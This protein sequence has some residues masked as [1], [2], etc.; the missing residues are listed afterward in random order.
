MTPHPDDD[1]AVDPAF[2]LALRRAG[3]VLTG[4]LVALSPWPFAS[5]SA[6]FEFL[7]GLGVLALVA[8]W[9]AYAATV[10]RL[11]FRPDAVSVALAGLALWSAGQLVPLPE[12]VVGV[13]G[14]ARLDWHRTLIPA[15]GESLPGGGDTVARATWLPLT[16]DAAATRTFLARVLGLLLLYAAVRN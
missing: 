7:L 10:G 5:N 15:V 11:S 8:L 2:P 14:P 3:E 13:V 12:A 4:G 6:G 9:A 16:V 1:P